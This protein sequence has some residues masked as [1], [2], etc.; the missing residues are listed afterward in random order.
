MN[1][2]AEVSVE[3]AR[4]RVYEHLDGWGLETT[5]RLLS[6]PPPRTFVDA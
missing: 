5:R 4:A 6:E 1:P 2:V 3:P